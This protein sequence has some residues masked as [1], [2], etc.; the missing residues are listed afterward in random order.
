LNVVILNG[1]PKGTLSVTLRYVEFLQLH[2]PEHVFK[3]F[4]IGQQITK[5]EKNNSY[6]EAVV[7][8]IAAADGLIWATPVYYLLVPAQ[9]KRF[10]ELLF[11]R[12][13]I[14]AF[15]GKPVAALTTSIH[16]FDNTALRYLQAVSK[17]LGMIWFG[18]YP[19]EMNDL[20]RHGE[21]ERLKNFGKLLL[22]F[23]NR[24]RSKWKVDPAR[25]L[26]SYFAY[27]ATSP[28]RFFSTAGKKVTVIADLENQASNLAAMIS[29][30]CSCFEE[31]INLVD[32]VEAGISLGCRGCLV[33][34]SENRCFYDSRDNFRTLFETAV[35]ESDIIVLGGQIRDR[36]LSARWKRFMDRSFYMNHVPYLKNKQVG[37]IIEGSLKENPNLIEVMESYIAMHQ[38]NPA[39]FVTDETASNST[40]SISLEILV[41]TLTT[42]ATAGYTAPQ[43]FP[44]SGGRKIF[45][46]FIAGPAQLVFP[47]DYSYYKENRFFDYPQ[48]HKIM[49]AVVYL[50]RNLLRL[51]RIRRMFS[52]RIMP[53]MVQPLDRIIAREKAALKN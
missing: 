45:R 11:E 29:Y 5:L 7:E 32:L 9:L 27:T 8:A 42:Y 38:G 46:D 24:D 43:Y 4:Q 39:G 48:R 50:L 47:A 25:S 51:P 31:E 28:T 18:A 30:F 37:L 21:R 12:E 34:G 23:F 53:G 15:R 40:I 22:Q 16:F 3:V 26:P 44:A 13:K 35:K 1:S 20:R 33:C 49:Q 14:T 10:I 36:F 41:E 52:Q 17:D 2:N 6:F 19:A